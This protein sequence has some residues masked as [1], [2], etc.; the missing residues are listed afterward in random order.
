MDVPALIAIPAVA[1]TASA[2]TAPAALIPM[3]PASA[4]MVPAETLPVALD[5]ETAPPPRIDPV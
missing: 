5:S 3:L 4:P 2:S 1:C